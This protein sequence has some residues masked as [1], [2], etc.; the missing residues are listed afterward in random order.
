MHNYF[1]TY[2]YQI[3]TATD[4]NA[5]CIISVIPMQI[6]KQQAMIE[7]QNTIIE[8]QNRKIEMLE[9]Q[10]KKIEILTKEITLIKEKLR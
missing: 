5:S 6:G 8:E 7:Q 1:I 9:L 4:L 2:T 10:N 3:K